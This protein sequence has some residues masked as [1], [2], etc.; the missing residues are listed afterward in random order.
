MAIIDL[1][2]ICFVLC[3]F[4]LGFKML[5]NAREEESFENELLLAEAEIRELRDEVRYL[6]SNIEYLNTQINRLK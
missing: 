5:E 1:L 3:L 4:S 2:T 6:Q